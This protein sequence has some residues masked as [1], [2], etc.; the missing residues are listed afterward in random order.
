[1]TEEQARAAL[2]EVIEPASGEK[3]SNLKAI[4]SVSVAGGSVTA[5]LVLGFPAKS[6][7][8]AL[9]AAATAALKAAGFADATVDVGTRITSHEAQRGVKLFA[10]R[11]NIIAVASGK[12]GV[13]KSTTAVNLALALAPKAPRSAC[14]TPT[15][16][17]RA[18]PR[19]WAHGQSP[20]S[21][22]KTMQPLENYG[23]Q[24]NSIGFLVEP[25]QAMIWRGPMA[26]QALEQLLRSPTGKT[27]TT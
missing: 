17:A 16:T 20:A 26:T 13:G 9:V 24:V 15:S 14:S 22:G 7:H 1:M 10:R 18:C 21:D 23:L 19:C 27:S 11:A 6:Q 8:P 5:Q 4:Q 2:A 12:G 25:D 3:L